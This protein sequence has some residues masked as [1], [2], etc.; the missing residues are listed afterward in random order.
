M[1]ERVVR[2]AGDEGSKVTIGTFHAFCVRLLSRE[3][4]LFH[5]PNFSI[6]DTQDQLALVKQ[7]MEIADIPG[8]RASPQAF[9]A[10]ISDAKNELKGPER[11]EPA[12]YF[13]EFVRR[14]YPVYQELLRQNHALDFDDLIM[15][16]VIYLQANPER[17]EYYAN[18]YEYILVDEYQDTN[19]AQYTLVKLLAAKRRN[20]FVVGDDDQSVYS[21]RGADIRNILEFERDYPDAREM[22]LEQNYR[23]T[24]TI[25]QAAHAVISHNAN[26]KAKRLW[27]END[28]GSLIRVMHAYNEEQEAQFVAGEV[29]RLSNQSTTSRSEMAV[30][31]RTNAQSRALEEAFIRASIPYVLVGGTRFYERR[32]V[33]DILAYLRLVLN[34]SDGMTLRRVINTPPRKI[35][36]TSVQALRR[37]AELR[38]VA[39]MEAV[40]RAEEVGDIAAAAKRSLSLFAEMM[41][42]L[43]EA[44]KAMDALQLLDLVLRATDYESYVKDGTDEGDERWSNIL[45]LRTVAMDYSH[46]PAQ[47]G[48]RA[49]LENVALLGDTDAIKEEQERVTLMT[50]H[51][52]KGLEFRVV[53]IIGM[54]ENLFPH[55]RSLDDEKQME[56]ERRLAYVGITRAKERLYLVHAA[57]RVFQGNTAVNAPSRFLMNIPESLWDETGINPRDYL[58][59]EFSS[60]RRVV[61]LLDRPTAEPRG[62]AIQRFHEG[63]RIRHKHFGSG[64]VLST[65]MTSDD[66]EVEVEFTTPKGPVTKKLLV[67]FAGLE[68]M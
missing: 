57:R 6:Y 31:Y 54:E 15:E 40:S 14:V 48:L 35:G 34:P 49:F 55:G 28:A 7:A 44:S 38:E 19:H 36:A 50:L 22:K 58:R 9:L 60:V 37:W 41:A 3:A 53:F 65:V 12:N 23:S 27:T 16:A 66:E 32:E 64:T 56:E 26:R 62:P 52:A 18:R 1:K 8:N 24:D 29:D 4:D 25:L 17:L 13:G 30:M 45:E 39:L 61:N 2:L 5:R 51:S 21:W 67:S 11:Y 10:A 59:R 20:L 43:R 46:L 63:D 47:E 68:K 33:K 42:E